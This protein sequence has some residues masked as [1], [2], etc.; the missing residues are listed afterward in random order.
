MLRDCVES[1][2]P[3]YRNKFA[4][5]THIGFVE[6]TVLQSITSEKRV[7]SEIHSSLTS[8]LRRGKTRI[9]SRPRASTRI[10]LP[11]ASMTSTV[12]VFRSSHGRAETNKA[13][14]SVR[15]LGKGR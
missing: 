9:T 14:T 15:R 10:L 13:L 5:L 12:S 7:L 1:L 2:A 4:V 3:I 11:T 6:T 8:S